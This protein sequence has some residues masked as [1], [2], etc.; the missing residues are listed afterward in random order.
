LGT[1]ILFFLIYLGENLKPLPFKLPIFAK[2]VDLNDPGPGHSFYRQA[3]GTIFIGNEIETNKELWLSDSDLLTHVLM[4][5]TTGSGKTEALLSLAFNAIASGSGV[6]YVDPKATPELA[7]KIWALARIV[8][9]EDD[10]RLLNFQTPKNDLLP[11]E[12]VSNTC[13]PFQF[14]TADH[15]TQLLATLMPPSTDNNSIFADKAMNLLAGVTRALVDLR[16]QGIVR[17]SAT[18]IRDHFNAQACLELLENPFLSDSPRLSLKTA[19]QACNWTETLP[20]NSQTT[21]FEQFGYAHSYFGRVLS[22]LADT[23]DH[24]FIEGTGEVD[25]QD[26]FL[27]RRILVVLLPSLEKSPYEL[28]ALGKIVLSCLKNAAAAGIGLEVE[29]AISEIVAASPIESSATGPF[30]TL[31]DEY[32]AIVT[33]GFET[34]LTQGRGLGVAMVVASQDFAGLVEAD[35]KGAHQIVANSNLKIFMRMSDPDKTWGLIKSLTGEEQVLKTAGYELKA[36]E[37]TSVWR[38]KQEAV[39]NLEPVSELKDMMEQTEGEAHCVWNG[40]LVRA[41]LFYANPSLT[42]VVLNISRH[43]CLKD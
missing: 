26:V 35:S 2:R 10:F 11:D 37:L 17:L 20:L 3:E 39:V 19:L 14:E 9:R 43:V 36:G 25:F 24:V 1:F 16:D 13:N 31:I 27:N 42:E 32:A 29:G 28:S 23:Y 6:F 5:G 4:L 8:G 41:N 34:L 21:F 12:R 7:Y 38:D 18:T 33:P 40:K 15:L 22:N 30:M